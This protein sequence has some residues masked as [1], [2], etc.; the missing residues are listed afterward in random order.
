MTP[1]KANLR[2]FFILKNVFCCSYL[3]YIRHLRSFLEDFHVL[4]A[5]V[6]RKVFSISVHSAHPSVLQFHLKG[7]IVD[8]SAFKITFVDR[9]ILTRIRNLDLGSDTFA[10]RRQVGT[11]CWYCWSPLIKQMAGLAQTSK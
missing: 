9:H 7:E 4:A 3:P 2:M 11:V 8:L 10:G 1:L 6:S 5:K